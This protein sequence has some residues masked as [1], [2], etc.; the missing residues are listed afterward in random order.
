[1]KK[2]WSHLIILLAVIAAA[3][4]GIRSND[5]KT[6]MRAWLFL[7]ALAFA[8]IFVLLCVLNGVPIAF[9]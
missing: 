8:L 7:I 4:I 2:Q 3:L 9:R 6:Y 5:P 1:M